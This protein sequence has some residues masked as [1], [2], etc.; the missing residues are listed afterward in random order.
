MA[1]SLRRSTS[2]ALALS[3]L[4]LAPRAA[5]AQ[6]EMEEGEWIGPPVGL[7]VQT[8][9]RVQAGAD[10]RHQ[11]WEFMGG[12]RVGALVGRRTSRAGFFGA[13]PSVGLRTTRFDTVSGSVGVAGLL[14][15]DPGYQ[16]R[17]EF[18]YGRTSDGVGP[19]VA[20]TLELGMGT[21][22]GH[23]PHYGHRVDG[24][25][26]LTYIHH[27]QADDDQIFL[28]FSVQ[29]FVALIAPLFIRP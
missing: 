24:G 13:G 9:D 28:G 10:V 19:F 2:L 27:L 29:T 15:I 26:A 5:R 12:L 6:D 7:T 22:F 14:A 18:E 4:A 25:L 8:W 21:A 23:H 20:A 3:L 16:A 17:V 1:P 11:R